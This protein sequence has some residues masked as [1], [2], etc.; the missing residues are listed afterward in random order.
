MLN[1]KPIFASDF[2]ILRKHEGILKQQEKEKLEESYKERLMEQREMLKR[3]QEHTMMKGKLLALQVEMLQNKLQ[4]A[5]LIKILEATQEKIQ[6]I[7][8]NSERYSNDPL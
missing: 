7:N 3:E 5:E 2:D 8:M 1:L 4:Q 6:N